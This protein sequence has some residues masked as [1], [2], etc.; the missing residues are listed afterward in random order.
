MASKSPDLSISTMSLAE[1]VA[2]ITY[3]KG[4]MPAQN[5]V[6]TKAEITAV[7]LYIERFRN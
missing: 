7:A 6:L 2:L 4:V 5:G 1:R 3:G